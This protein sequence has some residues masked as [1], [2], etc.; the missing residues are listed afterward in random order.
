[1]EAAKALAAT[2]D[3]RLRMCTGKLPGLHYDRRPED[4]ARSLPSTGVRSLLVRLAFCGCKLCAERRTNFGNAMRS[5][6]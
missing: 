6:K 4:D 5:S 2:T 1:M 3:R